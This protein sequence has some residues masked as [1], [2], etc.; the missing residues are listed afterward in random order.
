VSTFLPDGLSG[1][2]ASLPSLS[3]QECIFVGEAAAL[4]S[5]IKINFLPEDRRPRSENVSFSE[6][7]SEPRFT[8]EQLKG[9][10]DRMSGQVKIS[11]NVQVNVQVDDLPF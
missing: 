6:G 4:P 7:W 3:Q 9:I 8:V 2:V 1:L 10:A 11:D 5:R